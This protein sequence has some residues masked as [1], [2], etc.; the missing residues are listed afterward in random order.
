MDCKLLVDFLRY[1]VMCEMEQGCRTGRQATQPGGIGF[2]ESI[3]RL[4]KSLK[5]LAQVI[6]STPAAASKTARRLG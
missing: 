1:S 5:I 2:L 4:L 6:W 3:L